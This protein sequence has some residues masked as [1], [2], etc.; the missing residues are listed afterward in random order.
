MR[1]SCPAGSGGRGVRRSWPLGPLC[2][3]CPPLLNRAPRSGGASGVSMSSTRRGGVLGLH[4]G[5]RAGPGIRAYVS[6]VTRLPLP[7]DWE[8]GLPS[9]GLVRGRHRR[10]HHYWDGSRRPPPAWG[11]G[12]AA[13]RPSGA[14]ALLGGP[15]VPCRASSAGAWWGLPWS[16]SVPTPIDPGMIDRAGRPGPASWAA[17]RSLPARGAGAL[18]AGRG[19]AHARGGALTR[20]W[21]WPWSPGAGARSSDR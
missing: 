5:R 14:A 18:A 3:T 9:Q 20:S 1:S 19:S 15:G 2:N 10:P 12:A 16:S 17:Q 11:G 7:A 8:W 13:R 6:A 21:R 4:E